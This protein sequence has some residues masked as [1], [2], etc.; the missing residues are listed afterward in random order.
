M[1]WRVMMIN[2]NKIL[3]HLHLYYYDQIDYFVKKL[4]YLK[5]YEWDLYVT[6]VE[7]NKMFRDKLT[8]VNPRAHFVMCEN[9]GYDIYPFIKVINLVDLSKYDFVLKMHTKRFLNKEMLGFKKGYQW[10]NLLVDAFLKDKKTLKYCLDLFAQDPKLG[11]IGSKKCLFDMHKGCVHDINRVR[12]LC[13]K[14]HI[15]LGRTFVAGT[16][17]MCRANIIQEIKNLSISQKDFICDKVNQGI[18]GQFSHALERLFGLMVENKGYVICGISEM[19]ND[20][21]HR[22]YQYFSKLRVVS[23]LRLKFLFILRLL[24][25][26]KKDYYNQQRQI[27]FIRASSLFDEKWYLKTYSDVRTKGIDA[28]RHYVM[29]GWKEGR[30]PGP[31]F[32]TNEYCGKYPGLSEKNWCPLFHYILERKKI[33]VKADYKVNIS[34]FINKLSNKSRK[35][36]DIYK[37]IAK[38]SYFNRHWYLKTYPDVKLAKLDPIKHYLKHGWKEGRN[39]G[40]DFNTKDYLDWNDDVKKSK[41]NPLYHYEKYGRKERRLFKKRTCNKWILKISSFLRDLNKNKI[42]K[43]LLV[44]HELSYTGAPLSLLKAAECFKVLGYKVETVSLKDGELK[45]EFKKFGKVLICNNLNRLCLVASR[46]DYAIVNTIVLCAEYDVL[47][48]LLP[49]VWWIREPL[50]L[51]ES[52][53]YIRTVFQHAENIYTMSEYSRQEFLPYNRNIK[54]I[55]H[56]ID[57][58]YRGIAIAKNKII[59]SIIGSIDARKGQDLYIEAIKR[60]DEKTRC[61]CEFQIVGKVYDKN[62]H[63]KLQNDAKDIPQIKFLKEITNY[64][65]VLSYY[66]KISCIVIPS[67][68]EPTSRVALE[69]LMM[70]RPIIISDRVGAQY[71]L[72]ENYNGYIFKSEDVD[73]LSICLKKMINKLSQDNALE[74]YAREAYLNNNSIP[75]LISNLKKMINEMSVKNKKAIKTEYDIIKSSKFFDGKWYLKTYPDVKKAKLDPIDHYVRFGWKEGR[76]PSQKFNTRAYLERY[77]DVKSANINPLY[78]YEVYGK[79][80]NREIGL[81][82]EYSYYENIPYYQYPQELKDW[83]KKMTGKNLNLKNPRTFN[84]KMQWLKLY[85]STPIKTQLADKY[86]VR[87][88]IKEKIGEQYLVPLLGVYDKFE[89]IDFNQL[90][91]QFVIKCNHGSGWNIIVK[92]KSKL[93]LVDTKEKLDKWMNL[94]FA[95]MTGFELHYRDIKPKIIIEKYVDELGDALYDYR[96]FCSYGKVIQ[97][98]LDVNSGTPYHERKI[99]DRDW[100]E[101]DITVKW[102]RLKTVVEK[103]RNLEKMIKMSEFLSASFSLVRVDFYDVNNHIY[104]GEMTFT[105]MSGIGKF[106]PERE[107]LKLGN[108]IKLP[109][110]A[111]NLDTKTYCK[112][113]DCYRKNLIN[114]KN[115][116]AQQ[117][118]KDD[119]NLKLTIVIPIYNALADV[120]LCLSSLLEANLLK[121]TKVLLMDDCSNVETQKYLQ[122]FVHKHPQFLLHRNN[123]NLGF[124]KNCN[125]GIDLAKGDIVV[126]LNSD[127][128]VPKGFDKRI[129]QCFKSDKN[130]AFASPLSTHS[131][132]FKIPENNQYNLQQIDKIVQKYAK[133]EYP[134]ITPE[135]FCFAIRKEVTDKIGKLDE[136]FGKGYC[137]EDD[138]V[139]RALCNGYKTVLIDNLI[140]AHKSHASFTSEL[141]KLYLEHNLKIFKR[142]WENQQEEVRKASDMWRRVK[143]ISNN[144]NEKLGNNV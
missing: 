130:I 3:V 131:G 104:F 121:Q 59:F 31:N 85:D 67:R 44:S 141:R 119:R 32:N 21:F 65:S 122:K 108:M 110:T 96:F 120:K 101:L 1:F 71:A 127:T 39:P 89:D 46:C 63:K 75:I 7:E 48:I 13:D 138:L 93:D 114:F 134:I 4:G 2:K 113:E 35:K 5:G 22:S 30:N 25:L 107:D 86:L 9:L 47:K 112:P 106:N 50:K 17:F 98:W 34:S 53:G 118:S 23:F 42:K 64:K 66:E 41:M 116:L 83:F 60:L 40:P 76:N 135:G 33:G 55:K 88:W 45:P 140:V 38:S 102:P 49:T 29:Y 69:A 18:T 68:E 16:I 103:P 37:T 79:K 57:D 142:R 126:L 139:L 117:V 19:K 128:R 133:C 54:I 24:H 129:L 111:Y 97:I 27:E 136:V 124:I 72:K 123:E 80:E 26:I 43:I 115:I 132:L 28:I 14:Y 94:N 73:E 6:Y 91:N 92:D 105:S 74:Q 125:K 84:E 56:G 137:E 81:L 58:F 82:K 109:S 70:G 144:I 95:F 12:E 62:F 143:Y 77:S 52:N 10:R 36:S 78:H 61:K 20:I 90:P 51:L 15:L 11:M 87:D 99:F 100:N 8:K